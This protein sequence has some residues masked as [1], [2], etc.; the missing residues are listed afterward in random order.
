MTMDREIV[1]ESNASR[2]RSVGLMEV[3][4][5]L[6]FGNLLIIATALWAFRWFLF[7]PLFNQASIP[8]HLDSSQFNLLILDV[9]IV[10]IVGY[11]INDFRDREVDAV[12]RPNRMLVK[13]S[14]TPSTFWALLLG[15][16]A[17]GGALTFFLAT[18]TGHM[19]HIWLYPATIAALLA[20]A[21]WANRQGLLGNVMVSA[22]IAF[23]PWLVLLAE[24]PSVVTLDSVSIQ[25][26]SRLLI[27]YSSLMFLS[28]MA[29]EI[30]KDAEDTTGDRLA[31]SKS[32]PIQ[33]GS[34]TTNAIIGAFLL[35]TLPVE[36]IFIWVEDFSSRAL[37]GTMVVVTAA[38]IGIVMAARS[39]TSA[40]YRWLNRWLKLFM[41]LGIAQLLC[42][43]A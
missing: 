20:Y 24:M 21:F 34:K 31:E 2:K 19:V 39:R 8:F 22:L 14:I 41:L 1:K 17:L 12:N 15:L 36:A 13:Y 30:A 40:D 4:S 26:L 16:I 32:L 3:L 5:F 25:W 27:V 35:A 10:A 42:I 43:N 7:A 11:W 33:L 23:L 38:T 37:L 29:R 6:R 9:I 18:E 28:N